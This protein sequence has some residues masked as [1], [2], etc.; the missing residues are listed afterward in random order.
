[1]SG[2]GKGMREF[3]KASR[4]IETEINN[5]DEEKKSA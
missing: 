3:K 1:M 2:L 5:A 4:D